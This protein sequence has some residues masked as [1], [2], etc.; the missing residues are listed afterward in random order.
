M[1]SGFHTVLNSNMRQKTAFPFVH[2]A[3]MKAAGPVL[4]YVAAA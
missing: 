3:Q 1:V 4:V 2:P